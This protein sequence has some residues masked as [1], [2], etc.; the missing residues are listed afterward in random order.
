MN[1]VLCQSARDNVGNVI[2]KNNTRNAVESLASVDNGWLAMAR[3]DALCLWADL[4]TL[5]RAGS[6][7]AHVF[8]LHRSFYPLLIS[9]CYVVAVTVEAGLPEEVSISDDL[10]NIFPFLVNNRVCPDFPPGYEKCDIL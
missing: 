8:V 4:S 1:V 10:K 9:S 5:F 3:T 6:G 7:G 2:A